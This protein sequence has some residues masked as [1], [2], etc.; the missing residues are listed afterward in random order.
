[1]TALYYFVDPMCSWCYGFSQEMQEVI[2]QLP[3]EISLHYIMGGLAPDSDRPMPDEMKQYIQ[4]HWQTVAARTG[5]QFNFDFWTE[6][7]PRRST[8]P[9][10]RAVLA[11]SLQGKEHVP[12][13]LKTIQQAYYQQ[14]RNPADDSTLIELAGKIG[15]DRDRFSDELNS[16]AVEQLL[17]DGFMFKHRLGVQGFPTLIMEKDDKYYALTI[18]YTKAEIVLERLDMVMND[19]VTV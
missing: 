1:M 7:E 9:S 18:G 8:Y 4:G 14:A 11:A 12:V 17:N 15:L 3:N 13:M 5:A 6:C 10:C 2:R 16:P 19:R